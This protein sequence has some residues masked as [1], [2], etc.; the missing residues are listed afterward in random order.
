[1][2][3]RD[4]EDNGDNSNGKRDKAYYSAPVLYESLQTLQVEED[5]WAQSDQVWVNAQTGL[6]CSLGPHVCKGPGLA[7]LFVVL[8]KF[9]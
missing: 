2:Q 9:N 7:R 4:A 6:D 5:L 8:F 3:N 1:M